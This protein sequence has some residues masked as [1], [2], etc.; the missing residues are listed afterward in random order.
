MNNSFKK[1]ALGVHPQKVAPYQNAAMQA[2]I[3]RIGKSPH[4]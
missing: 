4:T 3:E 1:L 2:R